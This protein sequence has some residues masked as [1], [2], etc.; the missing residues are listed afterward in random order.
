MIKQLTSQEII[1][2][3]TA[4]V[5]GKSRQQGVT[6]QVKITDCIENLVFDEL[7]AIANRPDSGPGTHRER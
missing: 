1:Q 7:I 4:L 2:G 5:R 3:M 6:Q